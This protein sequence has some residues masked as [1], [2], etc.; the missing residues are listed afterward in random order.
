MPGEAWRRRR[1]RRRVACD[2]TPHLVA[3]L[4]MPCQAAAS[5]SGGGTPRPA[6][7]PGGTTPHLWWCYYVS[8]SP[9]GGGKPYRAGLKR[10]CHA[11]LP[12]GGGGA[13]PRPV[14]PGCQR[15]A[16]TGVRRLVPARPNNGSPA[17]APACGLARSLASPVLVGGPPRPPQPSCCSS[18]GV[19]RSPRRLL[20]AESK[21]WFKLKHPVPSHCRRHGHHPDSEPE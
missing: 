11:G 17:G 7:D 10:R 3:Q 6:A 14:L 2:G 1:R 15:M 19:P 8:E 16:A 12:G 18:K 13:T 4:E 5:E 20:A 9:G 21:P